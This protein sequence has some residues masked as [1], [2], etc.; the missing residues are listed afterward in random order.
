MSASMIRA[1]GLGHALGNLWL[2]LGSF[3]LY[4]LEA[5]FVAIPILLLRGSWDRLEPLRYGIV[6]LVTGWVG[7]GVYDLI[8]HDD[9]GPL[10]WL[11]GLYF[12]GAFVIAALSLAFAALMDLFFG[13]DEDDLD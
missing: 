1:R 12:G 4:W 9:P 11:F 6:L 13:N 8:R 7:F 5:T 3:V 10:A 2:D